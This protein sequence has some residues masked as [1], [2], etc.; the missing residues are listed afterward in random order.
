MEKHPKARAGIAIVVLFFLLTIM[1]ISALESIFFYEKF[2]SIETLEALHNKMNHISRVVARLGNTLDI[3][4]VGQRFEQVTINILLG[5]VDRI[6][7]EINKMLKRYTKDSFILSDPTLAEGLKDVPEG[8]HKIAKD[9]R[10]FR[11]DMS[12]DEVMLIHNDIDVDVLVLDEK[13]DRISKSITLALKKVFS[14]IKILLAVSLAAFITMLTVAAIFLY[15][16]FISPMKRLEGAA[17]AMALGKGG[18]RFNRKMPGVF[19]RVANELN[20][21]L[22]GEQQRARALEENIAALQG[23]VMDKERAIGLLGDFF[24]ES[25]R[26]FDIDILFNK[27]LHKVADLTGACGVFVYMPEGEGLRLK[28]SAWEE[29]MGIVLPNLLAAESIDDGSGV[30][31][32]TSLPGA[33]AFAMGLSSSGAKWLRSFALSPGDKGDYGRLLL[34]FQH[35][36][37]EDKDGLIRG[38]ASAMGTSIAFVERLREEHDSRENCMRFFNQFPMGLAVFEK[39]G[40]CVFANFVLKKFLGV[41]QDFDFV[42]DYRF[43]NDDVLCAQGIVTTISKAFDGFQT[44]F[45]IHYDPKLVKHYGFRGE[46]RE[47]R[48]KSFPLYGPGGKIRQ[49]ALI[50]EDITVT[51]EPGRDEDNERL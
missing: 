48:V 41:G 14:E 11:A 19:G 24:M 46:V 37:D 17:M 35:C 49:I 4:V 44:E 10:R 26:S 43:I 40:E 23:T 1:V 32:D 50:Y 5:D 34:L 39:D 45:I 13:L 7:A 3:V 30:L 8:W 16:R 18:P 51:D 2:T 38:I 31:V 33:P 47:L 12:R 27:V 28:A 36:P 6:D 9:M 22:D 20:T 25:G 21:I 29:E 15:L 42:R